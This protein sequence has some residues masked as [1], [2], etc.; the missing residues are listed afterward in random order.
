MPVK[1]YFEGIP[2]AETLFP[3]CLGNCEVSKYSYKEIDFE[4]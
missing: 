3:L 4:R 1:Y 2:N